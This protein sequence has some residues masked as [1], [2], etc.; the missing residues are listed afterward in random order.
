MCDAASEK[1]ELLECLRLAAFGFVTLPFGNV[2]EN[3]NDARDLILVV[4]NGRRDLFDDALIAV[5]KSGSHFPE[6]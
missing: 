4:A 5:A 1:S 2:T 3:K 6:D